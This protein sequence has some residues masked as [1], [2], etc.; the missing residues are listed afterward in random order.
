[1][2]AIKFTNPLRTLDLTAFDVRKLNVQKVTADVRGAA[3]NIVRRLP[4]EQARKTV[5]P[6]VK[7]ARDAAYVAVGVGV[8]AT[9]RVNA[10]RYDLR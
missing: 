2:P 10:R 6:A 8:I 4:V 5:A 7:V 9:Q 3:D 1:M